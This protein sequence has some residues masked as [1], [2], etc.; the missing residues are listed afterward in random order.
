MALRSN[1]ALL[2]LAFATTALAGCIENPLTA[3]RSDVEVSAFEHADLANGAAEDWKKGAQLIGIMAFELSQPGD[4]AQIMADPEVGNG[5]APAW[6]YIYCAPDAM[7]KDHD[8]DD[9]RGAASSDGEASVAAMSMVRAFRVTADGT[10][11]SEDD[12]AAMA[13]GYEHETAE[14]LGEIKIDSTD[15]LGAAKADE[16]FRKVAEGFNASVVEGV[17][18]HEDM[19]AWWFAAMSADGFVVATVDAVTGELLVVESMDMDFEMPTFEWGARDPEMWSA[20]PVHLEAEGVAEPDGEPLEMPFT[21]TAPMVGMLTI[22]YS[23]TYPTDGLHWAI[24][25]AEG[26]IVNAD[27]LRSWYGDDSYEADIAIEKAGDYTFTIFYMSW[28]PAFPG[29]LPPVLADG[30][31]YSFT[32]DLEP[33]HAVHVEH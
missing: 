33:G 30:V 22:D 5:L 16:R 28:T 3:M 8:D 24:L 23:Q 29:P 31:E 9:A 7:A 25:D 19:P 14:A 6:W 18:R 20:E 12:A 26:E 15:A 32:L 17:A 2:A 4:D 11:T 27:H 1:V 21:A 13:A 10:V